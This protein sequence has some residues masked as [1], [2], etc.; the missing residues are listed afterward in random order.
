MGGAQLD[1]FSSMIHWQCT[2]CTPPAP[3][4]TPKRTKWT[5]PKLVSYLTQHD[6]VQNN[7]AF[8]R[9]LSMAIV[10]GVLQ[11]PAGRAHAQTTCLFSRFG[12][13]TRQYVDSET[14]IASKIYVILGMR[15]NLEA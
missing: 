1:K 4:L 8:T 6:P 5:G 9:H 12:R 11:K 3:P 14:W 7:D 15:I 10:R 2:E 13:F